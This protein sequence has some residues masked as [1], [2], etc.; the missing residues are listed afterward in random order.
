MDRPILEREHEL[1]QLAAA[2]HE[3]ANGLGSVVLIAGEAGIGKSSLVEALPSVLPDKAELLVGY[4]DDLTTRRVLGPLRDLT[5]HVGGALARALEAVDREQVLE[6]LRAEL[7]RRPAPT[8]L[9]IEDAHWA[10]EATLDV[11]RFLVR[12]VTAIPV[13][14]VLTYRDDELSR[15]H[16]LRHL[17]GLISR[18]ARL[19]RLELGPLSAGAVRRL[20]ADSGLDA[21]QVYAVTSGNPFFVVEVLAAQ[22]PDRVPATVTEAVQARLG[23]LDPITRDALETLA[24]VPSAVERWLVEALI[25]D[26]LSVLASAERYGVLIIGSERLA[27]RH[28]LIRKSMLDSMPV[29]R[30]VACNQ[31]V[32]TALRLAGRPVDPSRIV[33]HAAEAGDDDAVVQYGLAAAREAVAAGSHTEA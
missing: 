22:D 4:C 1:A 5:P 16:P 8:V 29:A 26:W 18:S 14:L 27:F 19:R 17:L 11:L 33:H 23:R 25:P 20:G 28:E 32:L 15:E 6:E 31:A 7:V 24:V 12:R 2:A 13:V 21:D 9:V 30:R 10:D 3:A